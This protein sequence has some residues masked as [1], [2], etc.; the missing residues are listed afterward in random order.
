MS[1]KSIA[2]QNPWSTQTMLDPRNSNR[3]HKAHAD[4][5][6][7]SQ[8]YLVPWE[9]Q[10]HNHFLNKDHPVLLRLQVA[11]PQLIVQR[12]LLSFLGPRLGL[13]DLTLH[14]AWTLRVKDEITQL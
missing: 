12:R 5:S 11:I 8:P 14:A 13:H 3:K 10:S 4:T 1:I 9:I 2:N 6:D 7:P